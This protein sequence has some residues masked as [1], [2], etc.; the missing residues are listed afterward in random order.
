MAQAARKATWLELFYDLVFVVAIAKAV[1]A[2]GHAHD[3]H[4]PAEYYAKYVLMM[5]PLWWAWTGHT[6]FSNRFNTDDTLQRLMTFAQMACAISLAVFIDP[7]FDEHYHGFLFSY[8]AFRG[9]L[10]LMYW[11]ST[12]TAKAKT[13]V[14]VARYLANGFTAGVLVSLS[15][16][17]FDG[18]LKYVVLYA[19]IGV[20]ILVTVIGRDRLKR[21]PVQGHHM[22]ERFGLLTIILL[23]ESVASLVSSLDGVGV[24][25]QAISAVFAGFVWTGAIWWIYFEN[26]EGRIYGRS[27]GTGQATIYWHLLIYIF[28]GGIANTI[29]Y[30]IDPALTL[31]DY[32]LLAGISTVGFVIALELLQYSYHSKSERVPLLRNA[33]LVIALVIAVIAI[34]PSSLITLLAMATIFVAY[35][36]LDAARRREVKNA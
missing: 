24:S 16:L 31:I 6:L 8:A 34:S 35:A 17:L 26:L 9:L 7:N 36:A 10:V 2:L 15:S 19:G 23:G 11:R 22:P 33:A 32:K 3:G 1:H 28:L 4:I 12:F 25:S 18:V 14:D 5:V 21:A 30:A 13:N 20:D 27:L 29:R